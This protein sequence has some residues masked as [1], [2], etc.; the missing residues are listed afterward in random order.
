MQLHHRNQI[1]HI[2]FTGQDGKWRAPDS[3]AYCEH[4]RGG[5]GRFGSHRGSAGAAVRD[6][7]GSSC[8]T[9]RI[10]IRGYH[11]GYLENGKTLTKY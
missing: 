8:A 10:A 3:T 5:A 6:E 4:A 9:S 11:S 7:M 1:A 2:A